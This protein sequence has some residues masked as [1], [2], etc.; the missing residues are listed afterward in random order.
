MVEGKSAFMN[1]ATQFYSDSFLLT[2]Q[3]HLT[4]SID[5]AYTEE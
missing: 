1:D 4:S 2:N 3:K 5:Q